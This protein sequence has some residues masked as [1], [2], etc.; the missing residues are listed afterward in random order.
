MAD[1]TERATVG[2]LK[3]AYE[4]SG[5]A[6]NP[7]L[8]LIAGLATQMLGWDERF[9]MQ[10]ADNGFRVIRFD[11]RDIGQSTH[12]RDAGVPNVMALLLGASR[13]TVPYTLVDM[14]SDTAGLLD[15][16]GLESAHVVGMSMGGMIAQQLA[17]S[18]PHRVRSLTSMM[19]TPSRKVGQAR[20]RAQKVLFLPRPTN[21]EV[22]AQRALRVY[23][24]IGSPG[25]PFD[26]RGVADVARRSFTRGNNPAGLAR[27]YAAIVVSPDRSPGLRTLTVPTLVLHGADDPLTRSTV[28]GRQPARCPRR[29][30]SC[31][32]VWATTCPSSCGRS[33]SERSSPMPSPPKS[34]L[35]LMVDGQRTCI[36][37][38]TIDG[39]IQVAPR[40]TRHARIRR[41]E[42]VP[43]TVDGLRS[44]IL[45]TKLHDR[46]PRPATNHQRHHRRE[47]NCTPATMTPLRS[48]TRPASYRTPPENSR[49]LSK[50]VAP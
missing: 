39:Q 37:N 50:R 5:D 13:S 22:A 17:I 25:Y 24:A 12:L 46:L 1:R 21:Q 2:R 47:T 20:R 40:W 38:Q 19:S 49:Q 30:S 32:R 9:C 35:R 10:L 29:V 7:P 45:Y 11:N 36:D 34:A 23:R 8:L 41:Q 3:L 14:A 26:E 28:V 4:T 42:P 15:A 48:S 16:L 31:P 27:Q 33:S 43:L 6:D 44:A 18:H